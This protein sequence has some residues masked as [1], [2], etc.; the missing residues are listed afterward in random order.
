MRVDHDLPLPRHE[1]PG[2]VGFDLICREAATVPPREIRLIPA[3]VVV[4]VP[5]GYMLMVAARSSLP[6]KRGLMVSNGVGVIDQ[7]YHGPEDEVRVQVYNFTDEPVA[8]DRGDRLA[9]GILV[10][11]AQVDWQEVEEMKRETRGGFGST[12]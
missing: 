10:R 2:S 6:L 11:V 9:Q 4:E 12:G 7:D 5:P 1:T 3:N 8:V